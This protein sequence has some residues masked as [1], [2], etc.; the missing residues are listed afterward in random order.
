[1]IIYHKKER[2]MGMLPD[3]N[4]TSG[5]NDLLKENHILKNR[6]AYSLGSL[7]TISYLLKNDDPEMISKNMEHLK[8]TVDRVLNDLRKDY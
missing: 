3:E 7:E 2:K 1:M 8:N 6:I 5:R 4:E